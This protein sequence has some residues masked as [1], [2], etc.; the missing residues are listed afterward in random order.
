MHLFPLM[1]GINKSLNL[2]K[3]IRKTLIAITA[4]VLLLLWIGLSRPSIYIL[5]DGY[6]GEVIVFFDVDSCYTE[7]SHSIYRVYRIPD[8][9]IL[10]TNFSEQSG[11]SLGMRFYYGSRKG[12]RLYMINNKSLNIQDT[13]FG[14]YKRRLGRLGKVA[15]TYFVVDSATNSSQYK[16]HFIDS[17]YLTESLGCTE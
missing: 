8:S 16:S 6:V 7:E 9:G 10:K 5:P 3:M 4:V 15:Y 13:E 11:L 1:R 14:I 17:R 12:Q 2:Q